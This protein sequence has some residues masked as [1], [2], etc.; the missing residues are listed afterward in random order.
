MPGYWILLCLRIEM[1]LKKLWQLKTITALNYF[2]YIKIFI[3]RPLNF[4]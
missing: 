2:I 1:I 3:V 4:G